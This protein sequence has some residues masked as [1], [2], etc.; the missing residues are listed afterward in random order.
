LDSDRVGFEIDTDGREIGV[1][2]FLLAESIED[3]AFADCLGSDDDDLEG[4]GLDLM[5]GVV[6]LCDLY[7][8]IS[9][10]ISICKNDSYTYLSIK[11]YHSLNEIFFLL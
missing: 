6:H 5:L 3:G 2:E 4:S 8:I 10:I 9:I 11:R 7:I 1:V